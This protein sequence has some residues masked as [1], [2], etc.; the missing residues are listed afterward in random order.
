MAYGLK[1]V[2]SGHAAVLLAALPL[3][4]AIYSIFRDKLRPSR[5]FWFY[6]LLGTCISFSFFFTLNINDIL[7]GDFYLLL[8]VLSAAFGYVEGGRI[9][10]VYGGRKV[11]TWAVLITLPF[12]IPI[13]I[14]YF[15]S[16]NNHI[17][18]ISTQA[19]ISMIYLASISQSMG[20]FLWFRVLARGPMEKIALTQLL[21]PFL[22]LFVSILLLNEIVT[23]STW[24]IAIL[25]GLC[26]FGT[27]LEKKKINYN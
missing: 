9:S 22:T 19:W 14:F 5:K 21:Q 16:K 25:V 24:F 8:S 7:T 27:I 23:K 26:L 10:R 12:V 4:T 6:S 20:M 18:L 2:P 1:E 13:S 15:N 3:A 11:M 17:S